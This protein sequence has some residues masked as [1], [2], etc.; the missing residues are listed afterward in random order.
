MRI[1]YRV[2][3]LLGLLALSACGPAEPKWASD[4][5]VARSHYVKGSPYALTLFTVIN[6]R[7]GKGGHAALMVNAPSERAIFDPAGTFYHPH[8]PERNDVHFG[9][10]DAAV[11]FYKDYHARISWHVVE[12]TIVVSPE[13]AELAMAK[14]KAYGA[15]PKARCAVAVSDILAE[16][17]GFADA[18]QTMSPKKL[19]EWFGSHPGVTES[20]FYDDSPD[21]NGRLVQ[22]PPLLL[23]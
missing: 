18:P 10:S 1:F 14:I 20:K 7:S 16:L 11:E 9:M 8:L 12:Q 15:V 22:A 23:N 19:M 13:V 4:A 21:D 3:W 17:P 2:L 5:E 6:N